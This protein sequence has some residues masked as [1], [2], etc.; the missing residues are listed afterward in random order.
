MGSDPAA[1]SGGAPRWALQ[2]G[3]DRNALYLIAGGVSMLA[4]FA[5]VRA[6]GNPDDSVGR[7]VNMA[8]A[9]ALFA[10]VPFIVAV[11]MAAREGFA[12][13]LAEGLHLRVG[14]LVNVTI[15][16]EAIDL[17]G[18]P[19][20]RPRST[21]G[22]SPSYRRRELSLG[23]LERAV[24]ITLHRR[25]RMGTPLLFPFLRVERLWLGVAEPERLLQEL[26]QRMQKR[27]A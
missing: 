12:A 21:Y 26:R 2:T 11:Y 20:P 4:F 23:R 6:M 16:Y 27:A 10:L 25:M 18:G 8:T 19:A 1:P 15:P 14:F 9:L 5:M 22:V 7:T 13:L 17:V 24:E 3:V